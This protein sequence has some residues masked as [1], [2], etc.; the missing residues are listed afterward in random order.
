MTRKRIVLTGAHGYISS[1]ILPQ[2]REHY[3]LVLLDHSSAPAGG[4][5]LPW[6][7]KD[8]VREA[9]EDLRVVD[10]SDPDINAYREHFKGADVIIHNAYGRAVRTGGEFGGLDTY[11]PEMANVNMA[12]RIFQ[13]AL[14]EKIPRVVMASSNHAADWYEK[15][16]L[17][18]LRDTVRPEELPRSYNF[19]GWAKA[20]YEHLGFIF[21]LG[22]YGPAVENVQLRIGFTREVDVAALADRPDLLRRNLGAYISPR[23][24]AQLYMKAVE[25]KDLRDADGVP[26]QIVYGTSNNTRAFWSLASARKVLGYEPQDDSE[27]K[28]KEAIAKHLSAIGRTT[29]AAKG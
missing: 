23:D 16:T 1:L 2:L 20:A 22:E 8:A 10:L 13:L 7:G 11:A 17:A 3:D 29:P 15:P 4:T 27:Q 14:E 26:F 6:G 25:A 12:F 5:P 19:Y 9:P 21:A 18:G 28:Y 24:M